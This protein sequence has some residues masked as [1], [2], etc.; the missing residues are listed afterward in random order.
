MG[1][2]GKACLVT[3]D[4]RKSRFLI[5]RKVA[6]K[7]V[8]IDALKNELVE[9]ITPY[10]GKEFAEHKAIT[11]ELG[12]KQF[13]FPLPHH[14]WQRGTNENSNGLL[15]EY[16]PKQKDITNYSDIYIAFVLTK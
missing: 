10:R 1:K 7:D 9:T 2:H 12:G 11:E 4:D 13:Y 16:F 15:R 14:Q 8:I 6:V 5:C 3:F